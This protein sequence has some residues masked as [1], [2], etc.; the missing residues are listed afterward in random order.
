M[1]AHRPERDV[2]G[3]RAASFWEPSNQRE[4]HPGWIVGRDPTGG[5]PSWGAS[6][7]R[8]AGH[9]TGRFR[10]SHR[11]FLI[12]S[13]LIGDDVMVRTL[14][15]REVTGVLTAVN[16][17]NPADYGNPVPELLD[18]GARARQALDTLDALEP[19]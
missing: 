13:A 3:L 17:R 5:A 18:L 8:A 16:P 4:P 15:G 10:R 7:E 14:V 12:A 19:R 9:R 2:R 6:A 1:T 11:G